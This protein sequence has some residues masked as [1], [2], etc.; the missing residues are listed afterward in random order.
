MC[1]CKDERICDN[2]W[3]HT[4]CLHAHETCT[5]MQSY[6]SPW[7]NNDLIFL[8][9][10]TMTW[11]DKKKGT[12]THTLTHAYIMY[13]C[14]RPKSR[15]FTLDFNIWDVIFEPHPLQ[16]MW[17][18]LWDA[19]M[20]RAEQSRQTPERSLAFWSLATAR[21]RAR[22]KDLKNQL[23]EIITPTEEQLRSNK[24]ASVEPP[25]PPLHSPPPPAHINTLI[26][27]EG[28]HAEASLLVFLTLLA[29]CLCL[30]VPVGLSL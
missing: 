8:F 12:N 9:S 20:V 21:L 17:D 18:I 2:L 4:L 14:T 22:R 23:P 1:L 19:F 16:F 11:R 29:L 13:R 6:H 25:P 15:G 24:W 27:T 7:I 5:H 3:N 28:A 30:F 26:P 10:L